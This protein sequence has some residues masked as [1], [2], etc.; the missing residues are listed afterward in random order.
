MKYTVELTLA[1]IGA[2]EC[3][4]HYRIPHNKERVKHYEEQGYPKDDFLIVSYSEETQECERVLEMLN[5]A[6]RRID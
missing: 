1:Q 2:I 6:V 3:A 5:E 4:L